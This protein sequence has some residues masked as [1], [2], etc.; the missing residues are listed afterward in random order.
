MS[1]WSR[2][3]IP[4]APR[5]PV[6]VKRKVFISYCHTDQAEAE[7]FVWTWRNVFTHR[8]LGMSFTN[9]IINSDNPAYVMSRIRSEYLG[10]SSVTVVLMGNCTDSRRLSIGRSRLLY[11]AG[12]A[13]RTDRSRSCFIGT[14]SSWRLYPYLPPRFDPNYRYNDNTSY[15]RYWFMPDNEA[16]MRQCI[17]TAFDS[18]TNKKLVWSA[19]RFLYQ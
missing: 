13:F 18:R 1:D 15:A 2:S 10:D 16:G 11:N 8:A 12:L 4:P 6:P 3:F 9:D 5:I 17:E 19:R 14:Q 7:G